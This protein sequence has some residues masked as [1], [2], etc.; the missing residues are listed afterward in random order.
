MADDV[1]LHSCMLCVILYQNMPE[2]R[3]ALSSSY[4]SWSR[5]M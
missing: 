4:A 3:S 1:V 5:V 2:P